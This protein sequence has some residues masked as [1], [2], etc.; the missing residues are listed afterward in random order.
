[1]ITYFLLQITDS[2]WRVIVSSVFS[3]VTTQYFIVTLFI[4]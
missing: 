1:M 4:P 2:L 3:D